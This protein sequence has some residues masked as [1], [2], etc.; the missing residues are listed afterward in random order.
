MTTST[1]NFYCY[2]PRPVTVDLPDTEAAVLE[3][4]RNLKGFLVT[5]GVPAST[6]AILLHQ[7][8]RTVRDALA[9]LDAKALVHQVKPGY[10]AVTKVRHAA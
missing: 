10:Y 2:A 9:R 4:M 1:P 3:R 7:E 6:L 5:S 8:V